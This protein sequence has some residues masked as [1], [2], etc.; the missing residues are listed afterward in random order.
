LFQKAEKDVQLYSLRC[1]AHRVTYAILRHRLLRKDRMLNLRYLIVVIS[2]YAGFNY[3]SCL[4]GS[5]SYF[6]QEGA[7]IITVP[8][9]D[10][11]FTAAQDIDTS[12]R[13]A[14]S[15][16]SIEDFYAYL[17]FS[18]DSGP[19]SCPRVHQCL[20]HD[21][22]IVREEKGE[23]LFIEFPHF[24]YCEAGVAR[25]NFWVHKDSVRPVKDVPSSLLRYIPE[26]HIAKRS[27]MADPEVLTLLLPWQDPQTS[28]WYSAG[29]RFVR[30]KSVDTDSHYGISVVDHAHDAVYTAFVH[31]T[32]AII[33]TPRTLE[34][35]KKL[36]VSILRM[37]VSHAQGVIPYVFGGCSYIQRFSP[38]DFYRWEGKRGDDLISNWRRPCPTGAQSGFDCSG[39]V[40]RAAQLSGITYWCKNTT[41]IGQTF[42]DI[43]Q[44]EPLEEGDLILIKGHVM[45]ISDVKNNL[46]IDTVGYGSGVGCL[47]EASLSD[48]FVEVGTYDEL[49]EYARTQQPLTK[50]RVNGEPCGVTPT[51][52]LV[53]LTHQ[54]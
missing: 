30:N 1:L 11:L 25:S 15:S 42:K 36:F 47:H 48:M 49:H 22:G 28:V 45:I 12:L 17:A 51:V 53:R 8:I 34:Q 4:D 44:Q 5:G 43:P 7:V 2:L 13:G 46:Y 10:C 32:E 38:H 20:Y 14:S 24:Y 31:H 50:K 54:D 3:G 35:A 18:P 27:I 33:D 16:T 23:E 21:A 37:W 26:P 40:L 41:T 6:E 52:R 19:N 39:L 9:A 29:T